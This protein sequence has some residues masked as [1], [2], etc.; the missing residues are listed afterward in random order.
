MLFGNSS[1]N[2]DIGAMTLGANLTSVYRLFYNAT[3]LSD[4]NYTSTIVGWANQVYNNSAPYNVNG[5]EIATGASLQFDNSADGGANFADAG[6]AR[7]YLTGA[8]AGWTIS[9]DTRIN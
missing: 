8:T 7:D 9:G 4:S 2:Q 6:G 3:G 5:S 1:F